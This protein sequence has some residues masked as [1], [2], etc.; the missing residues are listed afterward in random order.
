M[1]LDRIEISGFKS[2]REMNLQLG[3]LNVLIGANGA[4]KSNL[5]AAF[6][7]LN[8]VIEGR[9]QVAVARAGGAASWLHFGPKRTTA[10]EVKL[11]FGASGYAARIEAAEDGTLFFE[12]ERCWR[13]GPHY[14]SPFT[15]HLGSGGHRET[16]LPAE[17]RRFP[18]LIADHVL[19][20]LRS[21]K[22]YH[23]HDTSPSAGVKQ[24]G[25]LDDNLALRPDASNLAAF[26]YLLRATAEPAYRRIIA[27]VRQVAPFLEDLQLRPDPLNPDSIQLEWR[28]VG[29]DDYFNGHTLS[30]GTLR[31]LCLATLLL[32]PVP[33][34]LVLIDEPEL[35]LHPFAITQ[36]AAMLESAATRTQILVA[37]QSVT[38]IDQLDPGVVVIVDRAA[39]QS[40]F[41]RVTSEEVAAWEDEYA[42]GEIWMKNVIGG[43]PQPA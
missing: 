14:D 7:L 40:T 6:G 22:V 43:R 34:S 10:I 42:L 23:F 37:T 38:L 35:G 21:W 1:A 24:K 28:E 11:H 30:D 17:A 18:G 19:H 16:G 29:S 41:R 36:I 8:Q 15:V 32:Q 39:G 13:T 27:A 9:L 4:G 12:D 2:I 26:L 31:F 5:V 3:P 33:P 20:T 25:K